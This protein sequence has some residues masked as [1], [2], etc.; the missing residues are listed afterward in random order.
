M[1]LAVTWPARAVDGRGEADV[2]GVLPLPEDRVPRLWC[3][4]EFLDRL[5]WVA[6]GVCFPCLSVCVPDVMSYVQREN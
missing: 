5:E 6:V 2:A 1:A 3:P 4:S